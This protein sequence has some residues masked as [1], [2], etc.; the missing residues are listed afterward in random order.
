MKRTKMD[1]HGM[2]RV[3]NDRVTSKSRIPVAPAPSES[4]LEGEQKVSWRAPQ[5]L[6]EWVERKREVRMEWLMFQARLVTHRCG[7]P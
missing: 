4:T 3:L 6:L 2:A 7:A 5:C 1:G